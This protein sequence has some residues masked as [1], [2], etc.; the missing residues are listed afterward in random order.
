MSMGASVV[1]VLSAWKLCIAAN[2]AQNYSYVHE[3][4]GTQ[5]DHVSNINAEHGKYIIKSQVRRNNV[6]INI[7]APHELV[8]IGCVAQCAFSSNVAFEATRRAPTLLKLS[9]FLYF[10]KRKPNKIYTRMED[11]PEQDLVG[12]H[13]KFVEISFNSVT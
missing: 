3:Q 8:S 2:R 12:F 11:A 7:N 13:R 1:V 4:Y 9:T 5:S 6:K 10:E